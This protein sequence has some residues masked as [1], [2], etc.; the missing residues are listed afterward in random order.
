MERKAPQSLDAM[1]YDL[2]EVEVLL[3]AAQDDREWSALND[4]R[5]T[6]LEQIKVVEYGPPSRWEI[7][8]GVPS[9]LVE[10]DRTDIDALVADRL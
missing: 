5:Q 3:D 2:A 4:Q 10:G 1:Y 9:H 8:A 7:D 6:T